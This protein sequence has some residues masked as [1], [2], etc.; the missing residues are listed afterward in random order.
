MRRGAVNMLNEN[1]LYNAKNPNEIP[2]VKMEGLGNDY[3]YINDLNE[4]LPHLAELAI[5]VSERHFGIGSDGLIVIRPS[6]KADFMMR[7]FNLDGSEGRMCGNG[8]R[9]FAKLVH[10]LGLTTKSIISIETLSGIKTIRLLIDELT[11]E[12]SGATVAMGVPILENKEIPIVSAEHTWLSQRIEIESTPYV[13]TGV[14][15]GNPHIVTYVD[16][17]EIIDLPKIGALFERHAYFPEQVN[18]EFV[19]LV[20]PTEINMRVWER[21]SGETLACGTGACAAV[22][23]SILNKLTESKVKVNL[24]G[25]QLDI[26]WDQEGT[27]QVYMTGPARI[28]FAGRFFR[29]H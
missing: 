20:S 12:V 15:M 24:L 2:F 16:N 17:L 13:V 19:E 21:G 6:K 23:A 1:Y 26:Y 4:A 7:M 29:Q 22:V 10:D 14:S 5:E 28:S 25:G 11:E 8:I 9:C 18:T 27:G 3:V